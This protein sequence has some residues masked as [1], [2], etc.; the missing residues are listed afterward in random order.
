MSEQ[1]A[2]VVLR[3][4]ECR[5]RRP[6][7]TPTAVGRLVRGAGGRWQAD[8]F[9]HVPWV[10]KPWT[11][12][13]SKLGDR[14]YGMVGDDGRVGHLSLTPIPLSRDVRTDLMSC[15]GGCGRPAF[16]VQRAKVGGRAIAQGLGEIDV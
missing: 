11:L 4:R 6:R 2:V 16:R 15:R 3:C 10:I 12:C 1:I 7:E 9:E 13:V 8:R 5:R 14:H